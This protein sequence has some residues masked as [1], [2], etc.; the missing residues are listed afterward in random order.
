MATET[1]FSHMTTRQIWTALRLQP[2]RSESVKLSSDPL[3]VDNVRNIVGLY[4]SPP[5]RALALSVDDKIKNKPSIANSPFL[6]M[7]PGIPER[8]TLA[9]CGSR[10]RGGFAIG[11]CYKRHRAVGFLIFSSRLMFKTLRAPTF[12]SSWTPSHS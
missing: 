1:G 3:F 6:S 10:H 2:H 7:M 11:K 4:L 12:T 8:R 9:V 5:N